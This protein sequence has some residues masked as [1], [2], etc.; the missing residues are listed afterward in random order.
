VRVRR[1]AFWTALISAVPYL[2][3]KVLWLG[4][5][6]VG[7]RPG[8]QPGVMQEPRM[9]VG[10]LI[11]I[12]LMLIGVMLAYVLARDRLGRTPA[13]IVLFVAGG[14]T[15]LLAPI[16]LGLPIGIALQ[17]VID[18][19]L[20]SGGDGEL[21][22]WV[23][24]VVYGS[25]AVM[26]AALVALLVVYV[27]GRWGRIFGEPPRAPRSGGLSVLAVVGMA[28]FGLAMLLW[29]FAGPG[30]FGPAGMESI[31]QRTVL[32]TT[33][34]LVLAGLAVPYLPDLTVRWPRAAWLFGWVGCCTAAVQGPS[35]LVLANDGDISPVIA[36]L[37]AITT[38]AAVVFGL[39]VLRRRS[40]ELVFAPDATRA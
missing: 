36:A 20:G 22:G 23:Y 37:T 3:L 14:A 13:W 15:G 21:E 39:A 29:G 16:L 7:I 12:G 26:G 2:V 19:E 8:E 1:I 10:N 6:D 24:A 4:G 5:A 30:A 17:W 32:T 34:A 18:G 33:G 9:V 31:A 28:P 35:Q 27:D 38:P 11:T 25:F 40:R